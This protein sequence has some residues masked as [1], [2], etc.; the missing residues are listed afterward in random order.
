MKILV[1]EDEP[2]L[3]QQIIETLE[4]ADWVPELSQDGIDALYR[5]TSEEWDVIVLDLG[6]PKLDGLTVLKGIR[7]ENINTPVV[8]LSARDTLTQ[9][10]EGLNAGA[11]D[12]LTKPFEMVELIARIRAQLR[13]ASGSAAPVLQIGDLSLDTRSS[14]VLWQGQ[15]VSLTALEYKVVAYFMHN[16]NKVISRTELV[17][18]IYKQDF[19]RDSNTV[20]VFIGRIRKKIAPKII[21]TVRGLGYQ[22][23]AE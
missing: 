15:A 7:D 13:R 22:L 11:D 6:L 1:V 5:A 8:I 3:G 14:K 4:G 19:D 12:Y 21:K 23:N 17:E 16:Q 20:E 18:H 10:V 9:R 2:R